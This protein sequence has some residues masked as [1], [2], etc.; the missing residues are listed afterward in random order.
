VQGSNPT[1]TSGATL[2]VV[3]VAVS[4]VDDSHP[5]SA[6]TAPLTT[7]ISS[8]RFPAITNA[9]LH[10]RYH[11]W[12]GPGEDRRLRPLLPPRQTLPTVTS[13]RN[14]RTGRSAPHDPAGGSPTPRRGWQTS[15]SSIGPRRFFRIEGTNC[16]PATSDMGD[17]SVCR[18]G[19]ARDAPLD[20]V[21]AG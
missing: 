6:S 16:P 3:G 13:P 9:D 11:H 19:G 21:G 5:V 4:S 14:R 18:S 15:P 8:R 12:S 7:A 10:R 17:G 20:S 2:G 1:G